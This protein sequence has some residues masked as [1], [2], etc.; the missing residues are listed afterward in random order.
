MKSVLSLLVATVCCCLAAS[1]SGPAAAV[2]PLQQNVTKCLAAHCVAQ[3]KACA[4]DAEC[5][6]G[7]KVH[8]PDQLRN[9]FFA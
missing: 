9:S 7:I 4:A 6:A 1:A 5:S 2:P 3:V 8:S